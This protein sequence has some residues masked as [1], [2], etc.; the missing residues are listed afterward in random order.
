[1]SLDQRNRGRVLRRRHEAW[2]DRRSLRTAKAIRRSKR[3]E[4]RAQIDI[5]DLA[6]NDNVVRP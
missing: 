1:M 5:Q 2:I 4:C 3:V 6:L